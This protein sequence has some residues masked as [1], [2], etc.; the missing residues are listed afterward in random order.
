LWGVAEGT[1]TQQLLNIGNAVEN[2]V[3]VYSMSATAWTT[4]LI[5]FTITANNGSSDIGETQSRTDGNIVNVFCK[6]ECGAPTRFV[7]FNESSLAAYLVG[8]EVVGGVFS[9]TASTAAVTFGGTNSGVIGSYVPGTVANAS[10]IGAR[11]IASGVTGSSGAGN[12]AERVINGVAQWANGT[13]V[14]HTSGNLSLNMALPTLTVTLTGASITF[15]GPSGSTVGS[16]TNVTLTNTSGGG[17]TPAFG[18]NY[19]LD[20]WTP[21]SLANN[22]SITFT[23][24]RVPAASGTVVVITNPTPPA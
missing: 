17:V 20:G 5:A 6:V 3:N 9:G 14:T 16:V 7:W 2:V 8:N 1:S 24:R 19:D 10:A 12:Y 4:A 15:T 21:V 23:A 18:G 13:A 22:E 11:L